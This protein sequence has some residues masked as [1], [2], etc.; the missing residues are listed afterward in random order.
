MQFPGQGK[1]PVGIIFDSDFGNHID[2]VLALA[3]LYGFDGKNEVRVAS[4]SVSKQNLKS[5]ALCEVVGRF[6]AGPITPF[7][8]I[9][10]VGMST[11]EKMPEDT[12]MLAVAAR[13]ANGIHKLNDTAEVAALIRNALTAQYDQHSVVLAAGPLTNLARL[14][15]LPGIK[16]LI[17]HKVRFLVAETGVFPDGKPDAN[18]HADVTA[19][20]QVLAQWPG[21]VVACGEEIGETLAFPGESIE[22]DFAWSQAHPVADAYRA[23]Q[24]MPY[25]APARSM[26][27][28]LYA[29]RPNEGYFKL[30]SPGTI[31][32]AADS[33]TKFTS[34]AEGRHRYLISDPAQKDRIVQVFREVASAKPVPRVPRF[35]QLQ[36]QKKTE[37]EKKAQEDKK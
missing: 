9:L 21:P 31:T 2:S 4:V 33:H 24:P 6:Y 11:E 18:I 13:Y 29:V 16:D 23:A 35:R 30:S 8:R 20:R 14:L 34:S 27:A 15:E 3:L 28:A 26:A 37:D 19:A 12:P 32:V 17:A 36:E 10:P 5:A 22:R 1:P 7:T 25:N